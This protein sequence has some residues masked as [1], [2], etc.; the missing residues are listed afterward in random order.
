MKKLWTAILVLSISVI[1][2]GCNFD[3]IA[4]L[5]I[6]DLERVSLSENTQLTT[7]AN[8]NFKVPDEENCEDYASQFVSLVEEF[9]IDVWDRGCETR[10][11]GVYLLTNFRLPIVNGLT[12]WENANVLFGVVLFVSEQGSGVFLMNNLDQYGALSKKFALEY[13]ENLSIAQSRVRFIVRTFLTPEVIA[14]GGVFAHGIPVDATQEIQL[15]RRERISI[16]LS[17]VGTASL[18]VSGSALLF[19]LQL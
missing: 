11:D 6:D 12:A 14:T 5:R 17:N 18:E 4:E 15:K 9:V 2:T 16:E 3:M 1:L 19:Y 7:Q 10:D 13:G 8:I